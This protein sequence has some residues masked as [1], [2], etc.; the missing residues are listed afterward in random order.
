MDLARFDTK[1]CRS[2]GIIIAL[3]FQLQE[4]CNGRASEEYSLY[5]V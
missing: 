4:N 5:L 1:L 3:T 2:C